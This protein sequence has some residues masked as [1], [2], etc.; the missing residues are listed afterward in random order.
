MHVTYDSEA[1]A[2]YI[3]LA[4]EIGAGGVAHTHV[5]DP[6]EVDGMIH[7]D[8]DSDG[9]LLGIEVLGARST[10]PPEVLSAAEKL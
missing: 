1:D 2:A 3:Q 10:L 4:D 8:F 7:L 9:R 5:C 6:V